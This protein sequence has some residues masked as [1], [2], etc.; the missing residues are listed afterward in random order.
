MLGIALQFGVSVAALQAANPTVSARF[1][2]I[3]TLLVI[4]P[5]E[6]GP[7]TAIKLAPPALAPVQ[8][9]EPACYSLPS[10]GLYCFVEAHN[11]GGAP[12]ENVSARIVLADSQGLPLASTIAYGALDLIPPGKSAPLV[13]LFQPAPSTVVSAIGV[14]LLTANLATTPAPV[15]RAVL[16]EVAF[17]HG[18]RLGAR[19][20]VAGQVRNPSDQALS[21]AW[22]MLTLYDAR[23]HLVG[24][25]KHALDTG[26]PAGAALNFSIVADTL[27]GAVDHYALLAEGRP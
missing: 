18:G 17:E 2:S 8:L 5:P 1:L 6:G 4:P 14:D 16:L 10:A 19:W 21:T 9:G 24:Y 25:R 22:V 12:L 20:T 15:G 23:G 27:G 11:P 13:V 7:A 3:G 26:L